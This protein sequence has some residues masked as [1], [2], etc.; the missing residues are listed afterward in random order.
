MK[1]NLKPSLFLR[2][3]ILILLFVF[4]GLIFSPVYAQGKS[5][6]WDVAGPDRKDLID[7][8]RSLKKDKKPRKD[9]SAEKA[10]KFHLS[11][12]PAL[13]YTLTTGWAG[14]LAG[15]VGF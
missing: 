6:S 14:I 12:V 3:I 11:M 1:Q 13:G 10:G 2:D 8:F 5:V 9:S 7:V 4:E 15:N